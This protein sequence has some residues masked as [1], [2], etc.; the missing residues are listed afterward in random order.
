MLNELNVPFLHAGTMQQTY[1]LHEDMFVMVQQALPAL[2][3][4]PASCRAVRRGV[5]IV[6]Y[7]VLLGLVAVVGIVG[8]NLLGGSTSGLLQG[9]S[10]PLSQG[11]T[12]NLLAPNQDQTINQSGASNAN[13]VVSLKGGGYYALVSDSTTGQP[14]LN[15]VDGSQGVATNVSSIDGGRMNVL[16]SF[17]LANKL[18]QLAS[19]ETV[20][21][22]KTY[23]EKMAMLSYYLGGAEGELDDVPGLDQDGNIYNNGDAL[24]DV[25]QYSQALQALLENPPSSMDAQA[26]AE[27]LPLSA[28]VYNIAKSYLNSLDQFIMP[29]GRVL[30]FANSISKVSGSGEPGSV[31]TNSNLVALGSALHGTDYTNMVD[32]GKMKTLAKQVLANK[33]VANEPVESTLT[34][35]ITIDSHA[36]N[37][38]LNNKTKKS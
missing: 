21:E 22:L 14:V 19:E 4:S 12:L 27:V 24:Q 10:Q 31:M 5:S 20:P 2:I 15:L 13:P 36:E 23:Y 18:E 25:S 1:E 26:R 34:D 28:D 11:G 3:A 17:M 8:L 37:T 7:S 29:D 35:A 6:E 38:R 16:G 30:P 33:G 9:A 32:Y